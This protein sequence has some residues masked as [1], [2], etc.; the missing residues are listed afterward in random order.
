MHLSYD[1]LKITK[2]IQ[3]KNT[4]IFVFEPLPTGFGNTL[5]NSLRRVLLTSIEGAAITQVK[6]GGANHQFSTIKGVKEDVVEIT[7]NLKQVRIKLH[8]KNTVVAT[9]K[10]KGPG[11]VTAADIE[12]S[13]EAEVLNKNLHIATLA[14]NKSEFSAELVIEPGYGYSPMEERQTSKIGV[15]VLDALFSPIKNASYEVEPTRFEERT[16]LDK[17]TLKVETDG[18]ISFEDAVKKSAEILNN[19]Y[20]VIISGETDTSK[21][22]DEDSSKSAE[23]QSF[24]STT[25]NVTVDDLPLQTRTV[26]ALK[27]SGI[28]TFKELCEKSDEELADIKNLGEK[29]MSEIIKLLEKEG[30][31]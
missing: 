29:S 17:L 4:G 12:L 20:T 19:Y 21:D 24:S 28:K 6:I 26:N 11:V 10:K 1:Q 16:D 9:I 22:L 27:K 3:D 8:T 23:K 25:E 13:S 5:G 15:I 14:D 30:Y 31:R 2:K 7:L 18:S